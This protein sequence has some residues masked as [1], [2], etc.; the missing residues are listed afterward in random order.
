MTNDSALTMTATVFSKSKLR[1]ALPLVIVA[2]IILALTAFGVNHAFVLQR[3]KELAR[4]QT[5]GKDGTA[6]AISPPS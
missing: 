3:D 4:L 5:I 1:Q 6:G 2:V